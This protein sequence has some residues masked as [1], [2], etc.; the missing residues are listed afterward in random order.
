MYIYQQ[1]LGQQNV[2]LNYL[3]HSVQ[4]HMGMHLIL[5]L[6]MILL[7]WNLLK[8]PMLLILLKD[9]QLSW[10][11][12]NQSGSTFVSFDRG[13]KR[14]LVTS[15]VCSFSAARGSSV[16]L[17]GCSFWA[18]A[19]EMSLIKINSVTK[20]V[21]QGLACPG[22]LLTALSQDSNKPVR[23]STGCTVATEIH[24]GQSKL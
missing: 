20:R 9:I 10:G 18:W 7:S 5:C 1:K 8:F 19:K 24:K 17:L 12:Q 11:W 14:F 15:L 2:L 16:L 21:A 22:R 6:K 23:S 3:S 13:K 4:Q